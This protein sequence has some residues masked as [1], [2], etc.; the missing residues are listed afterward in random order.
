[1]RKDGAETWSI[2][3]QRGGVPGVRIVKSKP[4]GAER[5]WA[6]RRGGGVTHTHTHRYI[7]TRTHNHLRNKDTH[8]HTHTR[9]RLSSAQPLLCMCTF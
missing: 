1:M 2:S 6:R 4:S 3:T 5:E 7:N 9:T 8:T